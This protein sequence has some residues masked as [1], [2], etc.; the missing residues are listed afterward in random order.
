M[1]GTVS[2]LFSFKRAFI[3]NKFYDVFIVDIAETLLILKR[4]LKPLSFGLSKLS[5]R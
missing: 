5:P 3:L 1:I 4:S 2:P